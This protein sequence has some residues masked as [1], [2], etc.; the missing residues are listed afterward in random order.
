MRKKIALVA[1]NARYTHSCLALYCLK[2]YVRDLGHDVYMREYSLRRDIEEIAKEIAAGKPDVVGLSVYIWNAAAMERLVP[3]LR[4]RLPGAMIV[5]GGPEAGYDPERWLR[6]VPGV[7]CVVR[8]PG[9]QGFAHLLAHGP[10]GGIVDMPNPPFAE[11]PFPY[12]D[13]DFLNLEKR[14]VYYESSRGCPFRC[15]YCISSRG[16]QALEFR[17]LELVRKELAAILSWNPMMVKFVDRT[18]NADRKHSREIWSFLLECHAKGPTRFHFEIHPA[19]L[20]EEDFEILSRC[21]AC[22]FNFEIGVQTINPETRSAIRRGGDWTPERQKIERLVRDGRV[23]IHLD[24]IAGLPEDDLAWVRHS[25]NELYALRPRHLQLGFLKV[26]PGTEMAEAARGY[27][28]AW[29]PS[30]PYLVHETA[31]LTADDLHRLDRVAHLVDR[32]HN[33]G[34]FP[35]TLKALEDLYET[36]FDLYNSLGEF[37]KEHGSPPGRRGES[38]SAFL[39]DF[40]THLRNGESGLLLSALDRDARAMSPPR[41]KR[42]RHAAGRKGRA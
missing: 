17:P 1:I 3:A 36:A 27:C 21:P 5:L 11:L 31:W 23:R 20:D 24:L 22:L 6:G 34:R 39:R 26:L 12:D 42:S 41:E 29:D 33:T 14:Y 4:Q 18:F 40:I 38:G 30:P 15:T 10:G 8:G 7:D 2:S 16:D 35:E 9:E 19:L 37:M 32:L 13:D 25:F 28:M